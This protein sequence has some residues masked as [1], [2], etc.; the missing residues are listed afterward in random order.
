VIPNPNLKK[1]IQ[2]KKKKRGGDIS[3]PLQCFY[4]PVYGRG[5]RGSRARV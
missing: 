4:I 1:N 5:K 2:K 3:A